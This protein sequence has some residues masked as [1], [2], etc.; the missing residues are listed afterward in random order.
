[1]ARRA[2]GSWSTSRRVAVALGAGLAAACAAGAPAPRGP[3]PA[4]SGVAAAPDPPSRVPPP[5]ARPRLVVG[6]VLDQVGADMLARH[7]ELLPED[8]ILRR[9]RERGAAH[10][11]VR[12]EYATT[13]T[14]PGHAA[15][16][17]GHPPSRTGIVANEIYSRARS[18]VLPQVDDGEHAVA[19]TRSKFASPKALRVEGVADRLR[20]A[21]PGARV[22]TLSIKD[23]GAILAGGARPDLALWFEPEARGFTTSTY[24][25]APPA[26]LAEWQS[27]HPL[28]ALLVPWTPLDPARY[29]ERLGPDDR[30]GEGAWLGLGRA[31]PH[32]PSRSTA[33]LGALAV[34]PASS[35]HLLA[36]ALEVALRLELGADDLPDLLAVSVSGTD[37]A[38]HV[39]GGESWE[40]V[41]HLV[42]VDRALARL[43]DALAARAPTAIVVTS[44]HGAAPLPE[45][46]EPPGPARV[47]TPDLERLL[48]GSLDRALGKGDWIGAV[49]QPFVYLGASA[50]DERS[51][52]RAVEASLAALRA[53]PWLEAAWEVRELRARAAT[54]AGLERQVALSLPESTEGDLYVVL[55]P[56]TLFDPRMPGG[57]GTHHG[58]PWPY[59]TDVPAFA[60]GPGVERASS[61]EPLQQARVAATLA[62]LLGVPSPVDAAPLPGVARRDD[63]AR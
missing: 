59:D 49:V 50:R 39:F 60:L 16:Y 10:E 21:R 31:F 26:W 14:A 23:R 61:T 4:T 43:Y 32:D 11:R 5:P 47:A 15:I 33:P 8:G 36:L 63:A 2:V 25:G 19:G 54:T 51:R 27:G 57:S 62:A 18:Q 53:Q 12:F 24:Y 55:K 48:E 38:G 46:A 37:Y 3:A 45:R 44:D 35:E 9:A 52:A 30:P 40:Y 56:G 20:A 13:L 28:A 41:D 29:A 7:A 42:R 58:A 34:M 17:T 6:V 22:A 1:M